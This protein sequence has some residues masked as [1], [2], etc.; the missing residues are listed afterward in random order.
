MKDRNKEVEQVKQ[1]I[2]AA[3]ALRRRIQSDALR[4]GYHFCVPFDLGF[5]ADPNAVF[6]AYGKYHFMFIYQSSEDSYRWGH[7]I[8]ADLVHW[9]LQP[10]ALVPDETDSGIYSGGVILTETGKAVVAY[11]ALGYEGKTSDGIRIA[12]SEPP[13]YTEWVK[14]PG[15]VVENDA[16]GVGEAI[17]PSGKKVRIASA[18]PSN[19]WKSG[20][21]YYMQL[22]N[23]CYLDMHRN[24][25]V[26]CGDFVELFVSEDLHDWKYLHRFYERD[27]SNRW[28]EPS[29]DDMCPYFGELP[30]GRDGG[31][32][33]G[34]YIQLFLAHN[35]GAQY[36]IGDYDE[37]A[38]KFIP[39][40]HGRLSFAD[41]CLFA[42]E[43]TVTPDGRL[44]SFFWMLDNIDNDFERE[45]L[46]GWSGVHALPR[47]LWLDERG[48]LGIAPIRE[49]RSLRLNEQRFG[50]TGEGACK[51]LNP[52]SC[53]LIL[54]AKRKAHGQTGF[55][56][57]LNG[58]M[59]DFVRI[60]VDYDRE[61]LI[62]D[63]EHSGSLG[64]RICDEAP[65]T[66]LGDTLTL[67]VF[68]DKC[69]IDVFADDRQALSRQVFET[70]PNGRTVVAYGDKADKLSVV[71]YE[72]MPTC[73]W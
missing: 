39:K 58:G 33:S 68:L 63:T 2:R 61:K 64:R 1:E 37:T 42:P 40:K 9:Q 46:K 6:Y 36:Y 10:D 17:D 19:I 60:C 55:R 49:I 52:D 70:A 21:K 23:L 20:G 13:F 41:K 56:I 26:P 18:D 43:A 27:E 7:A 3:H 50:V 11:W 48:E 22:G 25:P 44:I 53:E 14:R 72:M 71:A 29:E 47:E 54:T 31:K 62:L 67:N 45:I 32:M 69:M 59:T 15:Y 30:L 51:V 24:D 5:P 4:P 66:A 8:S 73:M 16:F 12:E 34:K 57:Y 38:Q 28:T 65:F 35:R